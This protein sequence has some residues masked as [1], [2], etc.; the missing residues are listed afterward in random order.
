MGG[1]LFHLIAGFVQDAGDGSRAG[2]QRGAARQHIADALATPVGIG[3]FEHEDGAP[4]EVGQTAALVSAFGL[5]EQPGGTVVI[6]AS[7]PG[8]EGLLGDADERGEVAGGQAASLP[9]VEQQQALLGADRLGFVG[10][11]DVS[12]R[13]IP[14][15]T[16][17]V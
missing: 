7:L 1:D 4:G 3:L 11:Q 10:R 17:M 14:F 9:E 8:M 5:V 2:G 6:E 12:V 16:C 15:L 13:P